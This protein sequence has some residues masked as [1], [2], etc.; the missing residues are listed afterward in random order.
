MPGH[1]A[2]V[3]DVA[4]RGWHLRGREQA[5]LLTHLH[6][7]GPGADALQDLARDRVRHH[8]VGGGL[9]HQRRGIGGGQAVVEPVQAKVGDRRHIDQHL[10][11][12][13][14]QQREDEELAG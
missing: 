8:A 11:D 7:H 9:E 10:R 3:D 12:H 4:D 5:A 14:E 6:R 2:H 1:V 13:H